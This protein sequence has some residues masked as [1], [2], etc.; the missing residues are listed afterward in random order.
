MQLDA[1][2]RSA[3]RYAPY[4]TITVLAAA[5]DDTYEI[6]R[7]THIG[8]FFTWDTDYGF[9]HD[10]RAWLGQHER[11]VFHSDDEVFFAEP[12]DE[13]LELDNSET[14]VTFRQGRNTTYCHPLSHVQ[15]VPYVFPWRWREA[16]LDFAY[17]LSLNATVYNSK[18]LLPLMSDFHFENPN[19]LEAQLAAKAN[20]FP[21][22]WMTAPE[23]S[24]TVS[25]PH[26]VVSA[27][28][29]NPRG[30]HPDWQPDALRRMYL[31]GWRIDPFV[32]DY[33]QVNAAHVEIPLRFK[34][35]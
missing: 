35:R 26:N 9:E 19:Q 32:M 18:D 30:A 12:P 13:L 15:A 1:F 16:S 17:P 21:V 28:S 14:L 25:L 5:F 2:L 20:L 10:V 3:A 7:A 23:R 31:D 33:S 29:G 4:K 27:S 8:A 34:P 11:V 22:A 6:C 24:C